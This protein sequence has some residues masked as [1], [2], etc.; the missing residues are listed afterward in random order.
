[1]MTV[2]MM[3]NMIMN[4]NMMMN[5]NT[6]MNMN[7]NMM[8]NMMMMMMMMMMTMMMMM[9]TMMMMILYLNYFVTINLPHVAAFL[10]CRTLDYIFVSTDIAIQSTRLFDNIDS[11]RYSDR[12]SDKDTERDSGE[13]EDA[14][15]AGVQQVILS[16]TTQD[17]KVEVE[18]QAQVDGSVAGRCNSNSNN[19]NNSNTCNNSNNS[20]NKNNNS[21]NGGGPY[22]NSTWPSDHLMILSSL[23]L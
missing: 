20:N 11:L 23:T 12:H 19:D 6:M 16:L 22:P 13:E 4:M 2:T 8:M 18:E 14:S 15:C 9:M 3:M 5:M 10:F 17:I 7:M 21:S 1:M